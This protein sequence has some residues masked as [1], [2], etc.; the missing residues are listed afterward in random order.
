[1]MWFQILRLAMLWLVCGCGPIDGSRRESAADSAY[2][3]TIADV[4]RIITS[5]NVRELEIYRDRWGRRLLPV[6]RGQCGV[7]RSLGEDVCD[8]ADDILIDYSDHH[9]TI[10]WNINGKTY[11]YGEN[12]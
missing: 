4:L 6:G 12:Y 5:G 1:M 8:D 3:R 9:V 10:R 7:L 2:E 11:E